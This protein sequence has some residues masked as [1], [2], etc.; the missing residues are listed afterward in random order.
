MSKLLKGLMADDIKRELSGVESVLLVNVIG[1]N[2][3]QTAALRKELR[4]EKLRLMVVKNSLAR[5]ATEGTV[6][7][8]AFDGLTGSAAV[9]W[10]GEDV[11][12]LAKS[13][14]K[15][16]GKPAYKG[17][18]PRGGVTDGSRIA[19][20]EIESVSKWPSREE[21]LGKI[22]GQILG[23]GARLAA[24]LNGPG[25]ALASQIKQRGEEEEKAE[26]GAAT[27]QPAAG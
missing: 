15:V 5:I 26:D 1:L 11:V 19:A 3:D 24:Q 6:L 16:L 22:V 8:P 27:E 20:E 18:A 4:G 23:P 2:S 7:A 21:L 9:V 12:S 13:V 10:G 14:V 25:G 17:I